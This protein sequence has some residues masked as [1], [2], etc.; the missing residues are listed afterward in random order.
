[1]RQRLLPRTAGA[2]HAPPERVLAPQ[3]ALASIGP[4]VLV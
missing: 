3:R 2:R 4:V 1:M